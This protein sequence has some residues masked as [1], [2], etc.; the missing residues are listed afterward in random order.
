MEEEDSFNEVELDDLGATPDDEDDLDLQESPLMVKL[1]VSERQHASIMLREL[2]EFRRGREKREHNSWVSGIFAHVLIIMMIS[3]VILMF[4]ESYVQPVLKLK[5][6][7]E[8]DGCYVQEAK[9]DFQSSLLPHAPMT[10][11]EVT[12]PFSEAVDDSAG[13]SSNILYVTGFC[14]QSVTGS[15]INS[16][17]SLSWLDEAIQLMNSHSP[18]TC[19]VDPLNVYRVALN[20]EE[21]VHVAVVMLILC[22]FFLWILQLVA[23]V[24]T[25]TSGEVKLFVCSRRA[26]AG[27]SHV[28]S[29]I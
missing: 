16:N 7:I 12:Y 29:E 9:L 6:W 22:L 21:K 8:Y 23:M 27:Y 1:S 19:Y 3:F 2:L 17:A 24:Q 10:V 18:T 13:D 20:K 26:N 25:C 5:D 14:T 28:S 11:F 15:S 4:Y